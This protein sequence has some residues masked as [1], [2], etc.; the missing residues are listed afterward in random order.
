LALTARQL[1]RQ[2]LFRVGLGVKLALVV[3]VAPKVQTTWFVPFIQFWIAHPGLDP[4][5]AFLAAGGDSLAFPYGV[6]MFLAHLPGVLVGTLMDRAMALDIFAGIGFRLSLLAA[7]LA[8]LAVL[9]R[10][11]EDRLRALML[12]YWLSPIA[13][14]VTY[15]HGQTDF[16]PLALMMLSLLLLKR[17]AA[18]PAGAAI[19]LAV[20]AKLSMLLAAPLLLLYLWNNKRLRDLA[21]PLVSAAIFTLLVVE[22]P[23]LLSPGF[24]SMTFGSPEI[25]KV[26]QL[27]VDL[28]GGVR[29]YLTP[30][31][32]LL[33]LYA[34]WR[35][36]RINFDLLVAI[37]GVA[38]FVVVLMTP[39]SV[40]WYLWVIPF[41]AVHQQQMGAPAAV[42]TGIF[43]ALLLPYHV[44][45]SQGAAIPLAALDLSSQ[46]LALAEQLS[47]HLRSLWL[48]LMSVTGVVL[49]LQMSRRGIARN[50]FYRL[51][52][53]P[54]GIGISGDSGTG[55]STLAL[56]LAG[57][58]GDRSVVHVT[59]DDYHLWEREAPMWKA[60]THLNPRANDLLRF[61]ADVVALFEG[62]TVSGRRYDHASGRF[63]LP[64]PLAANDVVIVAGLHTL[65]SP[66]LVAR[67]DIGIFL[68]VDEG[69][70]RHWKLARD[71]GR[72]GQT[73]DEVS[74]AIERRRPDAERYIEPQARDADIV[75]RLA[76]INPEL[77]E[78]PE[79]LAE[80]QLRLEAV[81]RHGVSYEALVRTLIGVC[82]LR[83]D[84]DLME[85]GT[86]VRLMVEGEVVADDVRLAA[87]ILIP[88]L[89]E[90]L[91]RAPAWRPH[92]L[93]IMQLISLVQIDQALRMR[94][95]R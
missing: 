52:R 61:T 95:W 11:Y 93:G 89:D 68:E 32:Y 69:L 78:S 86:M 46:G 20:A 60:L 75:F 23:Y 81:L 39:A 54:L 9:A 40:G 42:L 24:V 18:R 58:F 70:R 2:P 84:V 19:G 65:Y 36:R 77:L 27:S 66:E 74:A 90:L 82:G 29:I 1:W 28:G 50:D 80:S 59:G 83:L 33:V 73:A 62:E 31:V 10:L 48:T 26:Y 30:L 72:R 22:L 25:A 88:H 5:T 6:V 51:G 47:P 44:L 55:K 91:D 56:A 15:W 16:V 76:P 94:L 3:L 87:G 49:A 92:M 21:V 63:S 79:P 67:L 43:A 57:I 14:Y 8:I 71:T 4:W 64:E 41:L 7:D 35:L 13:L 34:A 45:F 17:E 37:L 85:E 12:Y 53:R 38:F